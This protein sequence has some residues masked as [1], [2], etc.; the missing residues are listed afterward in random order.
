MN[1]YNK[2][3]AVAK[4]NFKRTTWIAYLVAG[5]CVAAIIADMIVD[6]V[7]ADRDFFVIGNSDNFIIPPQLMLYLIAV[8]APILI[9]AKNYPRL[10]NIGVKK[11]VYF[12]GCIINYVIFAAAIS[13]INT[14][15]YYLLDIPLQNKGVYVASLIHV[16]GWESSVFD[17]FFSQFAFLLFLQ[18]TLHTL[19]FMQ[20]KWYGWAADVLIVAIISVFTPIPVLRSAEVFFFNMTLFF[21]PA[22]VHIAV[23]LVLAVLF[24]MTNLVYLKHRND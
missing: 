3:F 1:K 21:Q 19:S 12:G 15:G 16:F 13:L 20:T 11:K 8:L 9:A 2:Y 10:M 7:I 17:I 6:A 23:C 22:I 4:V 18:A 5:I 24:Y 14:V